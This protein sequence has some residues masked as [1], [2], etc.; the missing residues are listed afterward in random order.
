MDAY[1][2]PAATEGSLQ[3]IADSLK[4]RVAVA[5]RAWWLPVAIVAVAC[6]TSS[7]PSTPDPFDGPYLGTWTGTVTSSVIGAGT[8]TVV[9]D[10]GLKFP[11][12]V[13]VTG[14]WAFTF[15]D[16]RFSAS[17]TVTGTQLRNDPLF[18][19]LFSSSTVPCP[20]ERDGTAQRGRSA[21]LTLGSNRM[22]GSYMDNGCP[23]GSLDLV[24]K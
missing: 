22:Q 8:A 9:L 3:S 14:S 23:G 12:L 5:R 20:S 6:S 1:I 21:S 17:G 24:R 2:W 18:V 4:R 16:S 7:P 11:S 19:L 15:A 13:Q 10:S